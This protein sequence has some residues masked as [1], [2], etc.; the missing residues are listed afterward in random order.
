MGRKKKANGDGALPTTGQ[1]STLNDD[2]KRA[3]TFHHAR[4]FETADALVEKAK[5]ER[6]AVSSSSRSQR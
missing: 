6:T 1:N 3:L 2:E 4:A 5:A